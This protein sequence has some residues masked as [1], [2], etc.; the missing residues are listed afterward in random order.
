MAVTTR[1]RSY[2]DEEEMDHFMFDV[3]MVMVIMM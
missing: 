2:L 1:G 3:M